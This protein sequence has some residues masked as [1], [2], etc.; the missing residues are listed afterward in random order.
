MK[1]RLKKNE[2]VPVILDN[3]QLA[4]IRCQWKKAGLKTVFTN[5]CFD[6]IHVGHVRLLKEAAA[7]GDRLIVALNTDESIRRIKGSQRPL[8]PEQE[9]AFI[10]ASI[11]YVDVVTM[12]E[13]DTPERILRELKPDVLVKGG[14]YRVDEIVGN[15]FIQDYGGEVVPLHLH[16]GFSTTSLI[17]KILKVYS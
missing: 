6:L 11:Q 17:E 2:P 4:D 7:L 1:K 5:G 16:E 10:M 14:D 9:R 12:F 3:V 15:D 8:L 13:E